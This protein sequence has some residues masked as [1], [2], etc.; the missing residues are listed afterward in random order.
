MT[1]TETH[2]H[3]TVE[4]KLKTGYLRAYFTCEDHT[5]CELVELIE[6][7][8]AEEEKY[9]TVPTI[10]EWFH[11]ETETALRDGDVI[12][13]REEDFVKW[14]Y[15]E[16]V[17]LDETQE[18]LEENHVSEYYLLGSLNPE[19]HEFHLTVS[20]VHNHAPEDYY[21]PDCWAWVLNEYESEL[22]EMFAGEDGVNFENSYIKVW[23]ETDNSYWEAPE[24]VMLWDYV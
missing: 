20:C 11:G 14:K 23:T 8:A 7:Q 2:P 4:F 17:Q 19:T 13:E 10:L 24:T 22:F 12:L 21:S 1:L 16:Q 15:V 18:L 9:S 5:K 3:H 6:N